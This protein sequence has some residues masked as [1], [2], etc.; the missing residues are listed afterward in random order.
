MMQAHFAD[1]FPALVD[2]DVR[3]AALPKHFATTSQW[4]DLSKSPK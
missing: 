3:L 2:L 1:E 4:P